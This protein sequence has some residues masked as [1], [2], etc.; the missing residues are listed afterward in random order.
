VARDILK[1]R[2][3]GGTLVVTLTQGVLEQVP[4]AEGD[5]IL[6]EAL[7]PK[8]ILI[9]KEEKTVPNTRRIELELQILEAKRESFGSQ[10]SHAVAEYNN[11]GGIESDDLEVMLKYWES[12]RDKVAVTIA[13]KNLELFELQGA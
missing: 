13:E 4:M 5:R 3:V 10:M 7:P 9:S 8:C 6:I 1:V 2:K 11:H 12:E